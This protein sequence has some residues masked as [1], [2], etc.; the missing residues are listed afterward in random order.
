MKMN[1]RTTSIIFHKLLLYFLFITD[2]EKIF[3]LC[4]YA[5][6]FTVIE[7]NECTMDP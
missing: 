4:F 3:Y 1:K 7:K 2:S 5:Y 6:K